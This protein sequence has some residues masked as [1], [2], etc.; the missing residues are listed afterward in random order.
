MRDL[1]RMSTG[2]HADDMTN[3]SF[4]SKEPLVKLFLS[5]PVAHKAR[6]TFLVHTPAT[7]MCSPLC[8]RPR[9]RRYSII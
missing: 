9:G 1:L 7:F 5:I 2:Q 8:K 4:D 6:H 3:F